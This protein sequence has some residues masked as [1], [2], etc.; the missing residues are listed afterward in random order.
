MVI[1]AAGRVT[2]EV[3]VK[4]GKISVLGSTGS[5]GTQTLD[6]ARRLGLEITALAAGKNIGRLEEQIRQFHPRL[7]AVADERAAAE[8][9]TRVADTGTRIL[10]GADGV[11]EAAADPAPDAVLNAIV[12]LNGLR[13]TLAAIEAG[14]T[15]AL[16]N[17]ESLVTAG[18]IVMARARERGVTILPVDSEHSAIFQCLQGCADSGRE[19]RKIILTA[20]GGPFFGRSRDELRDVTP[21]QALR[22]PT[23]SMGAKITI[24]SATLMNKGMELIEAAWLFGVE[25]E[26]VQIVVQRESVIHSAVELSDH[27]VIAQLG[28]PDMRLPIQ[29]ALTWPERRPSPAAELDFYALGSLH[30]AR[31]DEVAFPCLKA[32]RQAIRRGGLAPAAVNGGNEQAVAL[33]LQKRIGFND[34]GDLVSAAGERQAVSGPFTVD[35]V[36][37]ADRSAREFVKRSAAG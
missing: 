16:A 14:K 3:Y 30:F 33:F 28:V 36:F 25:P 23:W 27:A 26:R 29:Y 2:R 10:A 8:L 32:C 15:L 18:A 13:S 12:G 21:E 7:A 6:V 17:K 20:S 4:I 5:I 1:C 22:H 19:L 37:A 11:A 24:D 9:K 31:P 35:D 34:I